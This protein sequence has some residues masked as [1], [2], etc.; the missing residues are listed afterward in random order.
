MRKWHTA[1]IDRGLTVLVRVFYQ[2]S[3]FL[4]TELKVT[5]TERERKKRREKV[6][7]INITVNLFNTSF[8]FVMRADK[9]SGGNDVAYIQWCKMIFFHALLTVTKTE[10]KKK[11]YSFVSLAGLPESCCVS[12]EKHALWFNWSGKGYDQH[13][14][15][16]KCREVWT[17]ETYLD[18][19]TVVR[20]PRGQGDQ[21]C[22]AGQRSC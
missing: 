13:L 5:E 7:S 20:H 16:W 21:H 4:H 22:N 14:T 19:S 6:R 18:T 8:Y 1:G 15:T 11:K 12:G 10:S 17:S 2:D 3:Q 9:K